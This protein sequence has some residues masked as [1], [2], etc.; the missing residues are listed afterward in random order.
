MLCA[1]CRR[2]LAGMELCG[3]CATPAPGAR[4]PLVLVLADGTHVPLVGELSIGRSRAS[5]LWLDDPSVSRRH[6]RIDFDG[7]SSEPVLEDTGSSFGTFVN[8][9][10][11]TVSTRLRDGAEIR[12][13]NQLLRVA[14][15]G[16]DEAAART[17]V[18]PADASLQ[19]RAAGPARLLHDVIDSQQRPRL[20]SGYVLKRRDASVGERRWV[21]H[22][23]HSAKFLSLA[24]T[25]GRLLQ[26][27]DGRRSLAE[28]AHE[29]QLVAPDCGPARLLALL[30]ELRERGLLAGSAGAQPDADLPVGRLRR[31]LR[32]RERSFDGVDRLFD[33]IYGAGGW[34]LFT[35]PALV[36][37]AAVVACGFG[38][39]V[40][41][42]VGRYGTP[43]V[44]A[45]R[46]VL[47]GLVF[48][49][50]RA[51]LVVMHE[52]AHGLALESIGRHARGAGF[53]LVLLFPYAYVDMSETWLE[54]RR[55]LR[56][57]VSASG[58]ISDLTFAG[59][60]AALCL[61]LEP[62]TVRDVAFQVSF[63][64]YAAA[65]FNLNPFLDRDG[66][67]ILAD[68]LEVPNLRERARDEL[69]R[70]LAGGAPGGPARAA[71]TRYA[72]AGVAW[73][74]AAIGIVIVMTVRFAPIMVD[75]APPGVVWVVLGS[76]W[77]A[78]FVPVL[79]VVGPPFRERFRGGV[80]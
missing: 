5:M 63:A 40:A 24:D 13:G 74:I 55:W 77:A 22:D 41:L 48:L 36:V 61:V 33:R 52:L 64:G 23:L 28:L 56:T 66:Y 21:L 31:V 49:A 62:G 1:T 67:H 30:A 78:L 8:G 29:A 50:G 80:A 75:Y 45:E 11:V 2:Q 60:F 59:L 44:V 4:P 7:E 58:P 15:Q 16:D 53:K 32:T 37:I 43:F 69:R 12:V 10:R 72:L 54:S 39:F 19:V 42:I 3:R 65:F 47:G 70:R 79:M 6:A 25:E 46:L 14:V 68:R 27:L 18:V 57:L 20:R 51:L 17:I 34:V 38:A 71:L 26:L 9:A 35:R 76:F 73:S